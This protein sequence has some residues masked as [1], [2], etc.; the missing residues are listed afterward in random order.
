MILSYLIHFIILFCIYLILALSLQISIGYTGLFN[1]G[2]IAFYAIG[3]YASA[4]LSLAGVPFVLSLA[5]AAI[6]S[7]VIGLILSWPLNRLKGDYLVLA[8]IGFSFIIYV[9]AL[10]WIE[11]TRGSLGLAGIPRPVIFNFTFNGNI[12]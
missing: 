5:A 8:T 9:V 7:M 10:N 1:F 11:L 12:S 3:A 2:H 4:L 6:I